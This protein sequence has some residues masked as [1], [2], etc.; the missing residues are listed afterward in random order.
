M[1]RSMLVVPLFVLLPLATS[2]ASPGTAT[3]SDPQPTTA[4]GCQGGLTFVAERGPGKP[5]LCT[6]GPDAMRPGDQVFGDTATG[7]T[8][9]SGA[10]GSSGTV[11]AAAGAQCV[12]AST[13]SDAVQ[14]VYGYPAG[15]TARVEAQRPTIEQTVASFDS[16]LDVHAGY[17]VNVVC[18]SGRLDIPSIQLPAIGSDEAFTYYDMVNGLKAAGLA[19]SVRDYVVF[20][21]NLGTAYPYCGQGNKASDDQPD[22]ARNASNVGPNYSLVNCLGTAGVHELVHTMGGVQ[23]SAP[24]SSGASHCYESQDIECYNDGGS[25]FTGGGAMILRC[26]SRL[27]DYVFDCNSDDYF[28]RLPAPAGTYLASHWNLAS[29][30]F[31]HDM[32][33]GSTATGTDSRAPLAY[34]RN[35][36]APGRV[37]TTDPIA[38]GA[39]DDSAVQTVA[40]YLGDSSKGTPLGTATDYPFSVPWTNVPDSSVA[41]TV[42]AVVTDS[43]GTT[44]TIQL[45]GILLDRTNAPQ[46]PTMSKAVASKSGKTVSVALSWTDTDTDLSRFEIQRSTTADFA[47]SITLTRAASLRS[48][49]DA[50]G[51]ARTSYYYRVRAVASSGT[52]TAWSTAVLVQT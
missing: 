20:T 42:T 48:T 15:T 13:P 31:L 38:V 1:R 19:S 22:P 8:L 11:G 10:L 4:S 5:P 29:S 16:W 6:H 32:H 37:T 39:I 30:Y 28:H 51:A 44:T 3:A 7:T 41:Q 2:L 17:R 49:S 18:T 35:P 47:S 34:F 23:N 21:D 46:T 27:Y 9:G 40:F 25:Y 33:V 45:T 24:H 14:F 26:G 12:D 43:V 36:S 50:S 52:R